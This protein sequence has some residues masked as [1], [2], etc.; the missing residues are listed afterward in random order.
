MEVYPEDTCIVVQK[1]TRDLQLLTVTEAC[2]GWETYPMV[3]FLRQ[4]ENNDGIEV[5]IDATLDMADRYCFF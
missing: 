4:N 1:H 2:P 3:T 5:D